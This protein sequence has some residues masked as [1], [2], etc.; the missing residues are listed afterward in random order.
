MALME[1]SECG[2]QISDKAAACPGCG[3]PVESQPMAGQPAAETPAAEAA[4]PAVNNNRTWIYVV[5]ALSV[6]TVGWLALVLSA[7]GDP[8]AAAA[9]G[10]KLNSEQKQQARSIA[11]CE[12]R[13][14]E[15][16]ADRQYTPEM[17]RFHS[18]T[19]QKMRAAYRNRWGRDP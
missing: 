3:A 1:C 12:E 18:M 15:M 16:N 14:K 9:T 5:A 11:F 4:V 8:R 2:R 17:L 6:A 10:S 19:C 13:Y 7:G